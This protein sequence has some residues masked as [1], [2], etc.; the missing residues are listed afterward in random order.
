MN[1]QELLSML[2]IIIAA[3]MV[4]VNIITEIVKKIFVFKETAHLN[5]FV[6]ILSVVLTV[7]AFLAYW[8]IKQMEITW[9]LF[10]AFIVIGFFVSYA[11]MFGFDKL[12]KKFKDLKQ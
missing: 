7:M 3:L 9:Y 8:Q 2:L 10:M 4:V 1:Y 6:V 12:I 5:A 11:A